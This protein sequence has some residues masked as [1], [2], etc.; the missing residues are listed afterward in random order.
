VTTVKLPNDAIGNSIQ[1]RWRFAS[2]TSLA[3]DGW[4]ID[5]ITLEGLI[6]PIDLATL[7]PAQVT[8]IFGKVAG[9]QS[10]QSVSIV[11]DVNGDGYDDMVIGAPLADSNFIF[12]DAGEAYLV[13]GGPSLPATIDLASPSSSVVLLG[14]LAGDEV[15]R[16]VADAGDIN[17]DGFDDIFV[18]AHKRDP[19]SR[20]SAGES[21]V[22]FGKA[23]WSGTP[24]IIL[25]NLSFGLGSDGIAFYGPAVDDQSGRSGSS[26]GDVNGDGFDD[27]LIGANFADAANNAKTN[28]GESY[29]IYG[30][31]G[32]TNSITNSP[33]GLGTS[34]SE[35][36]N[37][38]N[39]ANILN[40]ADGDDT[41]FGV[42]GADVLLGGRGNDILSVSDLTFIRIV[43]IE[44]INITGSGNNTLTLNHREVL[45]L[46]S[47]SNT[48]IVRRNSGDVVNRGTGW[49]QLA[50]E[51]I[52]GNTFEVF[53][54]GEARL[55]VQAV[56]T[57]AS[58]VGRQIFY[59]NSAGF[60]T[61]GANNAPTV[62]PINAIDP[63]KH[64]LLPGQTTTLGALV[65][66]GQNA[67][68]AHFTNYSR[69]LNG[70]VVDLNATTNLANVNDLSFQLA[71]WSSFPDATPN[72][73]TVNP[74]VTVSTFAGGGMGGSDRIKL[75]FTD[76]A[77]Q[78][79][80]LR[81][82]VLANAST[83]LTAT[84]SFTLAMRVAILLRIRHFLHK[85]L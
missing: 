70:I 10:G 65:L 17:G 33:N 8:T 2:D 15:G 61:N 66:G 85:F 64:A 31:N 28:A 26:A 58:V 79:S 3:Q 24:S 83:G 29:L 56:S 32:F 53:S 18:G 46:S 11:G 81:I 80:W 67:S 43:D 36:L 82:T 73:V 40:G 59:N 84:T 38:D 78:E 51:I 20:S 13:F 14:N 23:D 47:H 75:V 60:G 41:I 76:S 9:D 77:I 16:S 48:L 39:A 71:T 63:S 25:S 72:F 55:K 62:N 6:T 12:P 49:T 19:L 74:A 21:F 7:T 27:L 1:L 50:N 57:V 30:G 52:S 45:N 69:G 54:Q 34:V 37:G 35:T 22:I 44:E 5:S 4:S 68:S 42:G